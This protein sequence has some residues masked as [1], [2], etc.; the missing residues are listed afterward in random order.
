MI[1]SNI[2]L[3][4]FISISKNENIVTSK[5]ADQLES[6]AGILVKKYPEKY[7]SKEILSGHFQAINKGSVMT[8]EDSIYSDVLKVL[9]LPEERYEKSITRYSDTG[10]K[11]TTKIKT[12]TIETVKNEFPEVFNKIFQAGIAAGMRNQN[13]GKTTP[14]YITE[15][16]KELAALDA[17]IEKKLNNQY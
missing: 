2:N 17:E 16:E 5:Q 13:N 15:N 10:E 9:N 11:L 6:L 4:T 3:T 8:I 12:M 1:K 7:T 14:E